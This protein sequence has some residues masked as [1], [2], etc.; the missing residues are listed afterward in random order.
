MIVSLPTVRHHDKRERLQGQQAE[1]PKETKKHARTWD[2]G[3]AKKPVCACACMRA[4]VRVSACVCACAC[5]C[6]SACVRVLVLFLL[7]AEQSD[8]LPKLMFKILEFSR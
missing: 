1:H 4:R 2:I 5:T 8:D 3:R 6:A 7:P